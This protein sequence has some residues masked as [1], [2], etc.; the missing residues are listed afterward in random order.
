MTLWC[1]WLMCHS[2]QDIS[3]CIFS[4]LYWRN[5]FKYIYHH[6]SWTIM[7]NERIWSIPNNT[8]GIYLKS[9]ICKS[10]TWVILSF[11]PL[12]GLWCCSKTQPVPIRRLHRQEVFISCHFQ[13]SHITLFCYRRNRCSCLSLINIPLKEDKE[14]LIFFWQ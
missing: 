4:F 12:F 3:P 9:S 7:I 11:M 8:V 13:A 6:G 5:V 1:F 14:C 10:F 2:S